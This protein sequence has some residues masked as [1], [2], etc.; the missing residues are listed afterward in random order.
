M[1]KITYLA[2]LAEGLARWV[3]ERDRQD[4]LRYYAE[5]FDEAGPD[6]EAEVVAELGD[7]WALSCRLAVEGGY[8]TQEQAESWR[9][10]RK[11]R[12]VWPFVVAG[13]L[14]VCVLPVV[15]IITGA[16]GSVIGINLLG[17][18]SNRHVTYEAPTAIVGDAEYVDG[19]S[20]VESS[21]D[22]FRE[23]DAEIS[24]GTIHVVGGGEDFALRIEGSGE[25][26]LDGYYVDWEVQD[27]VLRLW[28]GG[29][30]GRRIGF[31]G[32]E[33]AVE[34]M[35]TVPY[36]A[37]LEGLRIKT[38]CGQVSLRELDVTGP[39]SAETD[40]GDVDCFAVRAAG[41]VTLKTDLGDI[42]LDA[43]GS[44]GEFELN[45]ACGDIVA[46]LDVP[47]GKCAYEL[48]PVDADG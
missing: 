19:S 14:L 35:V 31:E 21:L 1:D 32:L 30:G 23:I 15:V 12:K 17:T 11:R 2:E 27:G 29:T 36:D 39:V 6:R 18:A 47:E 20:V 13:V 33:G 44:G 4:I 3:P 25:G 10:R 34:V 40:L 9:P 38:D 26:Y 22:A 16:I 8:V 41:R 45:T 5:Y 28:D 42:A 46:Y 24:L 37:A 7:P 48:S 43:F